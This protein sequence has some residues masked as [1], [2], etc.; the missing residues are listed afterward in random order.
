VEEKRRQCYQ[1]G[2]TF[3]FTTYHSDNMAITKRQIGFIG[4]GQM[5]RAL[6][7]GFVKSGHVNTHQLCA[8]APTA[9]SRD[10]FQQATGGDALQSNQE[11]VDRSDVVFVAVKPQVAPVALSSF[12]LNR[13][14]SPLC[15]SVV[16]GL[17]L[18][19]LAALLHSNRNVRAMPTTPCLI[20]QGTAAISA[21]KGVSEEDLKEVESLLRTVA[22]TYRTAEHDLDAIT[23]MANPAYAFQFIDAL[24][25]GGVL[26][27]LK[28]ELALDLA[29]RTILGAAAMVLET[30]ESPAVLK[31]RVASPAGTTIAGLY[32]LERGGLRAALMR[33]VEAATLR[34]EQLGNP[35][36]LTGDEN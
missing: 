22:T 6:A 7:A 28:R 21:D 33:A 11:V 19:R 17:T 34:S 4:A 29:A 18:S 32:A 13:G 26:V 20:G 8:F 16:A 10:L 36:T 9:R 15:V 1:R 24:A 35:V 27:G 5:A 14:P 12:T 25:D 3:S 23:G 2:A 31:D 30:G